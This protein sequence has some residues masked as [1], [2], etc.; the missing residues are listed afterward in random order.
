MKALN[1]QNR[2]LI[3]K[4]RSAL[5][6]ESLAFVYAFLLGGSLGPKSASLA[7]ATTM[8]GGA[9][10]P[11]S[12]DG[13]GSA[14]RFFCPSGVATDSSGNVYV[15]DGSNNT[16]R[17]ITP[18]GDVTTLAGPAGGYGSDDGTGSAA[19]VSYP[20]GVATDSSCHVYVTDY[21]NN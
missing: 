17:K 13:T 4:L 11:G 3:T 14:A 18:A 12:A 15:A 21:F 2:R 10:S 9:A 19:R 20:S 16:I 5:G 7:V 8:P 1:M 6:F